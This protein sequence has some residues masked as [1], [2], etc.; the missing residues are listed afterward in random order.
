M[1]VHASVVGTEQGTE[2]FSRRRPGSGREC[3]DDLSDER[4]TVFRNAGR[5]KDSVPLTKIGVCLLAFKHALAAVLLMV[6]KEVSNVDTVGL[7]FRG[8]AGEGRELGNIVLLECP[9]KAKAG[10][11]G[12]VT[13]G[14]QLVK[15]GNRLENAVEIISAT[16]CRKGFP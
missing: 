14:A 3:R 7:H 6:D 16:I 1:E 10:A 9:R 8:E 12:F 11:A 5:I 4:G 13:L 15:C 2:V